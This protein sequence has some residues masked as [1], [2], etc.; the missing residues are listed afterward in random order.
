MFECIP[1]GTRADAPG[2][3]W[4]CSAVMTNCNRSQF[5]SPFD[6]GRYAKVEG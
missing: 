2:T 4:E 3:C 1:C 5:N 6:I